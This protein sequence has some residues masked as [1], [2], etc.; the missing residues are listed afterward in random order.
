ME[1]GERI[2]KAIIFDLDGRSGFDSFWEGVD[3]ETKDE[4]F[5][6]LWA[7]VDAELLKEQSSD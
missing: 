3:E 6:T 1:V 7:I 2:V 4:I 5:T